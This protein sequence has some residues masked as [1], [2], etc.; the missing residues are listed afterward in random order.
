VVLI[1]GLLSS[2]L[3]VI[4][5]FPYYYL[6]AEYLRLHIRARDFFIWFAITAIIAVVV[7]KIAGPAYGAAII[8]FSILW[9]IL[10]SYFERRLAGA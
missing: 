4:T 7:G 5:V 10:R 3:L 2:T 9:V 8:P 6:G 1:F